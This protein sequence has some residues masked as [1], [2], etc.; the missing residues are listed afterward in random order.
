MSIGEASGYFEFFPQELISEALSLVL[1]SWEEITPRPR[2]DEKED[3]ITARLAAGMKRLKRARL[4]PFSIHYQP[5][6]LG[7]TGAVAA[8]IDFK[9]LHG[10]DEDA[11]LV[12]ECKR[13][14]IPRTTGLDHN[15]GKYVGAEGMGRFASGKYASTQHNGV[16]IG[17]VMD[18]KVVAAMRSV[19]T[20]AL[21]KA[22]PL[23][24]KSTSW[25]K[26]KFL[27][28]KTNVVAT[29]HAFVRTP[30]DTPLRFEFQ[31]VFLCV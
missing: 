24:M 11:A 3:A 13:L 16:M 17:Y 18:G 20:A 14:R 29:Q 19:I 2:P 6:P 5:V 22:G 26:S 1:I 25:E 27:P 10:Y 21:A 8:R 30:G 28:G 7:A 12:F 23:A 4:L 9:L 15:T 31:H